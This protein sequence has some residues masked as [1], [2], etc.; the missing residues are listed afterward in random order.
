MLLNLKY[1]VIVVLAVSVI[2]G[3][4]FGLYMNQA[5]SR[6]YGSVEQQIERDVKLGM[7]D[8]IDGIKG[9]LNLDSP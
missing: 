6:G 4:G 5:E 3:M 9:A 1:V 7:L 8:I 2:G